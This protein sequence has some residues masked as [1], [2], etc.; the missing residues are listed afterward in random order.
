VVCL[1]SVESAKATI[2]ALRCV[3]LENDLRCSNLVNWSFEYIGSISLQ[4]FTSIGGFWIRF[5]LLRHLIKYLICEAIV[6]ENSRNIKVRIIPV[7]QPQDVIH[8]NKRVQ[9][10]SELGQYMWK[11]NLLGC[12]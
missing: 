10:W 11:E 9:S 7:K 5:K 4:K 3:V 8:W 1:C 12:N 2:E 6:I